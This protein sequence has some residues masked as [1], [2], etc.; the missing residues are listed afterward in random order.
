MDDSGR[1]RI[2]LVEDEAII[3]LG[4]KMMLERNGYSIVI[5]GNGAKAVQL[6][7]QDPG[8]DLV[9]M[10]I[11]LG[12]GM[13]GTEAAKTILG[14]RELPVVFLSSHTE[15]EVVEKTEGVTSFGYIVKNSGETVMLASIKMAFRLFDS[16]QRELAKEAA[17][18]Q[19]QGRLLSIL[20]AAPVGIGMVVNRVVESV[21]DRLCSMT[22]YE[23]DELIGQSAAMLYLDQEEFEYVGREKYRQ[24][25]ETGTG[26]VETR[27][28][29][30]DGSLIDVLLSSAPLDSDDLG[31]GVTF[32][33][34]DISERKR[35]EARYTYHEALERM[36]ITMAVRFLESP[37]L[38]PSADI[39]RTL[40]ELGEFCGV[41]RSYIFTFDETLE[42]MSNAY[43]WCA[44]GIE[45]QMDKLQDC[46]VD[47]APW[48]IDTLLS[49]G[50]IVIPQI[51]CMPPEAAAERSVLESQAI[52]S[53]L[54]VG[55]RR[56]GCLAG[57]LGFDSV[58]E[59]R[60]WTPDV[61]AL[62]HVVADLFAV[63]LCRRQ[64][65]RERRATLG[66]AGTQPVSRA[67]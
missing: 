8:I 64:D 3:A 40:R 54:V 47:I 66:S 63:V 19:S 35:A 29:C 14:I 5:A 21:N 12:K 52:R 43:E 32:T 17:L 30:K 34:M 26:M 2:L 62:M 41:D 55:F 33:A 51:S 1:K 61:V 44:R 6:A 37:D 38:V 27:W 23:S 13:D 24:I 4:E 25:A 49:V 46:P 28:R 39:Q 50:E 65:S 20:S 15:P 67:W 18:V 7:E 56:N 58:R 48:W 22:G 42:T 9:L 36:V 10:D 16:R 60:S 45:P 11:D 31:K 59:E 53:L 57:Y